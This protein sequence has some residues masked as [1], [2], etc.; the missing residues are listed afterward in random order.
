MEG[1]TTRRPPG[2]S[3]PSLA[4]NLENITPGQPNVGELPV[5]QS[6]KLTGRLSGT[7]P[8]AEAGKNNRKKHDATSIISPHKRICAARWQREGKGHTRWP[9]LGRKRAT[10][11]PWRRRGH[12]QRSRRGTNLEVVSPV[13][14]IPHG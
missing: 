8:L 3:L 7:M 1:G 9:S 10:G 13:M 2:K 12:L 4:R 6:S 14:L 11:S 5:T